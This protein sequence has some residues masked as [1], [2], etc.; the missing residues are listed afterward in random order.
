[1]TNRKRSKVW[2]MVVFDNL[3][4]LIAF[5]FSFILFSVVFIVVVFLFF[6]GLGGGEHKT[7]FIGLKFDSNIHERQRPIDKL[8]DSNFNET[9]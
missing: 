8:I 4:V 1:M 5:L 9:I 3:F 6:G 7:N 2:L